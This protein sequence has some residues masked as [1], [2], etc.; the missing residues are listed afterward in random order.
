MKTFARRLYIWSL[1][2]A[3]LTAIWFYAMMVFWPW[4]TASDWQDRYILAATCP[5]AAAPEECTVSY[6]QAQQA[7]AKGQILSLHNVAQVGDHADTQSWHHWKK[8]EGKPW[9]IEMD[10]S[11]W[12]FKESIRYRLDGEAHDQP[13]LLEHRYV[14]PYLMRYALPLA[15]LTL[16]LILLRRRWRKTTSV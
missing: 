16:L 9:Q 13:V 1:G 5:P 15:A 4:H 3:A 7:L 2:G 11:S 12:D 8:I 6:G 10:W 14:G